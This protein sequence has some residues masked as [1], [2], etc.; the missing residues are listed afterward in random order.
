MK[1][2]SENVNIL[3]WVENVGSGSNGTEVYD[4]KMI[5]TE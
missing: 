2:L 3:S 4:Q 1:L 5:F